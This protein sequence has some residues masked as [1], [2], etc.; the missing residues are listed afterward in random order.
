MS[1]Y[2]RFVPNF[3]HIAKP[4][5]ILV[6]KVGKGSK[7]VAAISFECQNVRLRRCLLCPPVLAYQDFSLL[8]RK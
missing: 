4:L 3:T 7:V 2:R 8:L 6:G 1:Y 5:H